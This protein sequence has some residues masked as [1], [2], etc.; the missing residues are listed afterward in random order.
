MPAL[1]ETR[2]CSAPEG[3]RTH[4]QRG[5]SW[6]R[7]G[8]R[9]E[10]GLV[11]S[12]WQDVRPG[13]GSREQGG[14]VPVQG[15]RAPA[16]RCAPSHV[17]VPLCCPLGPWHSLGGKAPGPALGAGAAAEL[18]EEAASLGFCCPGLEALLLPPATRPRP[19]T[20][21]RSEQT[22]L[23]PRAGRGE[24]P[25]EDG[26]RWPLCAQQSPQHWGGECGSLPLVRGGV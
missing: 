23:A 4:C 10:R 14:K 9:A 15:Q 1:R 17:W 8:W 20:A 11:P 5:T 3:C 7:W 16:P 19:P 12:C 24:G 22:S 26:E 21:P 2:A 18:A 6:A 13:A 25:S